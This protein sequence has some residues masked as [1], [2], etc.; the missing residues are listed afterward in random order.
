VL[1]QVTGP[2]ADLAQFW[3]VFIDHPPAG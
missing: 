2:R 1:A 3:T